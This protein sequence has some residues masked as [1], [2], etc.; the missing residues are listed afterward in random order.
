M[1]IRVRGIS[2]A[3]VL[4]VITSVLAGPG[5]ADDGS[6]AQASTTRPNIVFVLTDDLSDNLVKY[7]PSVVKLQKDGSRFS[8]YYV[9]DS[10]CCPS[11][12]AIFTGEYP[13]NNGVYTNTGAFGGYDAFMNNGDEHKVF[14]S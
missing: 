12:S 10:L 7:M 9:V 8:H 5:A 14:A 11:R 13:H 1:R 2:A 6:A 4:A 3:A